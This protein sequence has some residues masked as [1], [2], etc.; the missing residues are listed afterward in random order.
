M[1]PAISKNHVAVVTGAAAGIG[2]AIASRLAAE[3]MKVVM[4]D[5]DETALQHA[6]NSINVRHPNVQLKAVVGDVTA[7]S[8]Q[9]QLFNTATDWGDVS[10]LI[11]NVAV[12]NAA[13]PWERNNNWRSVMEINFWAALALQQYFVP[14]LLKQGYHSAI[15]NLGSK[16]GITTPP[17]NAA[18]SVSKAAIKVLTEQLA[19]ELRQ[20]PDSLISAH[21][22]VPG[23]TFTPMNYPGMNDSTEKPAAMWSADQVVDRMFAGMANDDFYIFCE[24]N[25]VSWPLD[26]LRLQW[27]ADDMILNRPALSRWHPEYQQAFRQFVAE[28]LEADKQELK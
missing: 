11:N 27:S 21:L 1:H 20:T 18:Y 16:E 15:V 8:A 19:H 2:F 4:F 26:Q 12:I 10:L 22:L 25:E 5:I 17:G 28:R 24:D 7:E 23:Y 9:F 13:G 14:H 3:G 6:I